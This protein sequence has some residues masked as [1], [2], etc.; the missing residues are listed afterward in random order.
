MLGLIGPNLDYE[1]EERIYVT[2]RKNIFT[3]EKL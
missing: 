2:V 3:K 1:T